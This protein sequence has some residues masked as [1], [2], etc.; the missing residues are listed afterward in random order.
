MH[1]DL[2]RR[3]RIALDEIRTTPGSGKALRGDLAGWRA[4]RVRRLRIVYREARRAIEVA[5]IGPRTTI[6]LDAARRV[7]RGV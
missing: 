1:P 2:K 3:V 7:R 6:Y 4:V 5:A